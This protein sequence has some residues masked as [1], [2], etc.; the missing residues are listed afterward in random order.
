M[1]QAIAGLPQGTPPWKLAQV[2]DAA[3]APFHVVIAKAQ[4]QAR[5]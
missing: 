1:A 2:R 4:E 5:Q 3:L